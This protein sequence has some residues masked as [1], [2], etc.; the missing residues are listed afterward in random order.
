[1]KPSYVIFQHC[2]KVTNFGNCIYCAGTTSLRILYYATHS[3]ISIAT[4][5]L[6]A[7]CI[8]FIIVPQ[9]RDNTMLYNRYGVTL[10]FVHDEQLLNVRNNLSN[11]AYNNLIRPHVS[12]LN[13]SLNVNVLKVTNVCSFSI[14]SH[15]SSYT[16]I[17]S[18]TS[19]VMNV[20]LRMLIFRA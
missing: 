4:E 20:S 13:V 16:P 17:T 15:V 18:S 12:E 1:M 5:H 10:T 2:F 3:Y 8:F 11:L 6:L 14:F 19:Y 9:K 7:I